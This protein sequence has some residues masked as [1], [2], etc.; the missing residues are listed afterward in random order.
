MFNHQLFQESSRSKIIKVE[1]SLKEILLGYQIIIQNIFNT[2]IYLNGL[3]EDFKKDF[4]E[5]SK[6]NL[7]NLYF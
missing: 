6:K 7:F 1:K 3:K 5:N 4:I 2:L